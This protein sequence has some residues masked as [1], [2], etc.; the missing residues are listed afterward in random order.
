MT[1]KVGGAGKKRKLPD[2]DSSSSASALHG[3]MGKVTPVGGNAT[4][5]GQTSAFPE[6]SS[7]GNDQISVPSSVIEISYVE[8]YSG[9]GGWTMALQE[10]LDK[11]GPLLSSLRTERSNVSAR[12][13][14]SG[15]SSQSNS[16]NTLPLHHRYELK[17]LAALDHSDLCVKVFSHNFGNADKESRED[18]TAK[19]EE[20]PKGKR[21]PKGKIHHSKAPKSVSIERM[22]LRQLEEWSADVWVMSPPCQPHTRQHSNNNYVPKDVSD[23]ELAN[24]RKK[25]LDDPRS[26]SFLKICEW[27]EGEPSG[28]SSGNSNRLSDRALP[29]LIFLENVVGFESSHSFVKWRSALRSRGYFVGHFHLTPTQVGLPNDRPRHYSV[30]LRGSG[31]GGDRDSV[32]SFSSALEKS[33]LPSCASLLSYL[34][35]EPKE[36]DPSPKIWKA[37]PELQVTPENSVNETGSEGIAPISSFLDCNNNNN[38]N[39][40]SKSKS[41]DTEIHTNH[42]RVPEK[43]LKNPSA[44]CFDIV[45]TTDKRSSCFTHSYGRFI[46]GTGSILYDEETISNSSTTETNTIKLLPPDQREFEADWMDNLETAK[47]RYFSGMELARLFGFSSGFSFPSDASLKQQWKLM[48]N[49][50]NVKVASKLIE[51]GFMLRYYYFL[52]KF[53]TNH[54]SG[55]TIIG[56]EETTA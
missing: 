26:K 50:L 23:Q 27:L 6:I 28:E 42:L 7:E 54:E 22:P 17:R 37:M 46:R 12:S 35:R 55:N 51:L 34:C 39:N 36:N 53:E 2:S 45:L 30:A 16:N 38:N 8:F 40:K 33:S 41:C 49:S 52:H 48:G 24:Q 18:T 14:T 1:D 9:V 3:A 47:L 29:S 10:A 44:W 15:D 56:N 43:V 19:D 32:F 11:L 13:T 25:D 4:R 5:N 20:Q 31:G 21:R